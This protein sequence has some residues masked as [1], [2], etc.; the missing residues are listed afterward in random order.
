MKIP[1]MISLWAILLLAGLWNNASAQRF[2]PFPSSESSDEFN[3]EVEEFIIKVRKG[4]FALT[5]IYDRSRDFTLIEDK[6]DWETPLASIAGNPEKYGIDTAATA[7]EAS[8]MR[9]TTKNPAM[10]QATKNYFSARVQL[11]ESSYPAK[12]A[13]KQ[14]QKARYAKGRLQNTIPKILDSGVSEH[15]LMVLDYFNS[16]LVW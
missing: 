12:D 11:L 14:D 3:R 1:S 7:L 5:N 9:K 2:P 15:L 4:G 13:E 16:P 10:I 6:R 8:I